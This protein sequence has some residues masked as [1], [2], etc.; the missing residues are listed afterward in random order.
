MFS[1]LRRDTR[2]SLGRVK[3]VDSADE[4]DGWEQRVRVV[5]EG[6]ILEEKTGFGRRFGGN[7]E[8]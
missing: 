2:I 7:V 1:G 3:R 6:K 8:T 5:R 4:L